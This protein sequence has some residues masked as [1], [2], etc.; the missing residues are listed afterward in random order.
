MTRAR[1]TLALGRLR[2]RSRWLA[3]LPADDAVL[4][5]RD[6]PIAALPPELFQQHR[7]LTPG[8]VYLSY[9]GMQP[10]Q[11]AIHAHI[12]ALGIGDPLHL[13]LLDGKWDLLD[14]R[15]VVVGR[16]ASSFDLPAD[17]VILSASVAAVVVQRR[18]DEAPEW[19]AR[20]RCESWE[21]VLAD[22]VLAPV[23]QGPGASIQDCS[24][25]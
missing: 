20:V 7:R 10:P 22:L 2:A 24:R 19:T 6:A 11:H 5:R 16:L 12:A 21:V 4:L 23:G 14:S 8:D 18:A 3:D 25:S 15:G 13:R 9:A 17:R 1:Q